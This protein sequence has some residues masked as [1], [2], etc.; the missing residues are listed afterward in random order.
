MSVDQKV[1]ARLKELI[2][3]GE[4]VLTTKREPGAGMIGFDSFVDSEKANQWFTSA[5]SLLERAFGSDGAHY[6]NYSAI[7]GKQGLS[8]SPCRRGQGILRAALEDFERGFLFD[9]RKLVE[10]EVFVDF[11]DQAGELLRAGYKAPAAVVAG[12]V[13][14]DGLRKLCA[15]HGIALSDRPKLDAMNS[16]LAKV[17]AYSLLTQKRVTAVADIRNNAAHGKWDAFTNDD[18]AD[19]IDWIAKFLESQLE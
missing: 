10:S 12:A 4:S 19:M 1:I 7:P 11:L 5:Q 14:E 8:F 13:L 2:S 17:S 6:K 16:S 9:I 18:V 3:M 15:K